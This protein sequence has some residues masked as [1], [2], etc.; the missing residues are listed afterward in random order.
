LH[1]I[2]FWNPESEPKYIYYF[3]QAKNF[4]EWYDTRKDDDKEAIFEGFEEITTFT[5]HIYKESNYDK[6]S[7][8]VYDNDDKNIEMEIKILK[9]MSNDMSDNIKCLIKKIKDK[10]SIED[11]EK[12]KI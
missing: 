6:F 12:L 3:G 10:N 8:L 5:K 4:E 1:H 9:K 11:I 2:H 7:I